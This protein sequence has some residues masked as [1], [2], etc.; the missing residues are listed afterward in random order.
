MAA[1]MMRQ[2]CQSTGMA[3][4]REAVISGADE[5]PVPL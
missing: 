3:Q 1:F 2:C 4:P 5:T